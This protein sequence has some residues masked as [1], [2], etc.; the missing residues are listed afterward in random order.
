MGRQQVKGVQGGES[1]GAVRPEADEPGEGEGGAVLTPNTLV[2]AITGGV[3]APTPPALMGERGV[4]VSL[5]CVT[6]PRVLP[7]RA[8]GGSPF[9]WTN[10]QPPAQLCPL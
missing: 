1:G 4:P 10:S 8:F 2:S 3:P 7:S 6:S 5:P 9:L